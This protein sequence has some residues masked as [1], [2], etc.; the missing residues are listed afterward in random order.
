MPLEPWDGGLRAPDQTGGGGA[1]GPT[2]PTGA[3][4]AAG[5]TGA[6]GVTGPTGPT[7]ATGAAGATGATGA[8]SGL[9][10]QGFLGGLGMTVASTT[11]LTVAAGQAMS[12]DVTT[13][14]FLAAAMTKSTAGAWAAGTGQNGMGNG[15]TI[16][17]ATWYHV[18]EMLN[19]GAVDVY[20]DTSVTAANAPAGTTKSRRIGSFLTNGSAQIITFLQNGNRFDWAVPVLEFS[21]TPGVTTAVTQTLAAVPTGIAVETLLSGSDF[22]NANF[23]TLYLS[24]LAQTD[25]VAAGNL[26]IT[27]EIGVAAAASGDGASFSGVRIMTNTAGQIRRRLSTTTGALIIISNGWIDRRGQE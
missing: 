9:L 12:S 20:F 22:D 11:T 18:F 24:S 14:M 23:S 25:G 16:A 2:G 10:L 4:G 17:A 7:G 3:T 21:G 5:P 13:M 26:S 1:T 15:L 27:V 8:A 19:A 6:T